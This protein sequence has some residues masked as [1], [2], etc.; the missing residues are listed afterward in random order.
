MFITSFQQVE[1][2][3][4]I[5]QRY[6]FLASVEVFT[7][8]IIY[9]SIFLQ[10]CEHIFNFSLPQVDSFTFFTIISFFHPHFT[11]LYLY[12]TPYLF[13]QGY[14]ILTSVQVFLSTIIHILIIFLQAY[15]HFQPLFTTSR[16]IN[17]FY[18]FFTSILFFTCIYYF[19][20]CIPIYSQPIFTTSRLYTSFFYK[21]IAFTSTVIHILVFLHV[22]KHIFN[23]L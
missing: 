6:N 3:I 21:H 22:Y 20:T 11:L 10:V 18:I 13:F 16:L 2:Y 15:K 4:S 14:H 17:I 19:S 1:A 23:L 5:S 7:S 8:I 12:L 9:L